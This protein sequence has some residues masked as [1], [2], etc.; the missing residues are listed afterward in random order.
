MKEKD[1]EWALPSGSWQQTNEAFALAE[2]ARGRPVSAHVSAVDVAGFLGAAFDDARPPRFYPPEFTHSPLTGKSLG[3]PPV[4]AAIGWAPPFG[5]APMNTGSATD[6][7]GLRRTQR[8]LALSDLKARRAESEPDRTIELPPP[9]EYQFF[10]APFAS[11]AASLIALDPATASLFVW[12]AG[13]REWLPLERASHSLLDECRLPHHAWRAEI[14]KS[15][16]A[17]ASSLF[18]PTQ[19]G[20]ACITPDAA[21]LSYDVEHI[22]NAPAVGSPIAFD[23]LIW[24]P[25]QAANA[26]IRFIGVDAEGTLK[27][28]VTFEGAVNVDGIGLPVSYSR[29][30]VWVCGDGQLRLQKQNDGVVNASFSPWPDHVSP[31]FEFGSPYLASDGAFW[32]FCFNTATERYVCV[33]IDRREAEIVDAMTPRLCSGMINFRFGSM[34]RTPP[35]EE[36]EHAD[37][38]ASNEFVIPLLESSVGDGVI[39]L[40]VASDVGIENA[41][42]S[43]E[44]T[45]YT[46]CFD[47]SD[48]EVRFFSGNT[49]EPWRTRLFIHDGALWAY[50]SRVRRIHGWKLA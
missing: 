43:K 15:A 3:A 36:P 4:S 27:G 20:L 40:R 9:G 8:T 18:V 14:A 16:N 23:N 30:A 17:P 50:H 21:S 13:S 34:T 1:G 35:W 2:T 25:L 31:R 28:E 46:L 38:A 33:R 6:A 29:G 26:A 19:S 7:R 44:R 5:N 47:S 42:H 49:P 12:L 48:N 45:P 41:L 24:V 37:D 32:Q 10:S 39:G 22:G 11:N